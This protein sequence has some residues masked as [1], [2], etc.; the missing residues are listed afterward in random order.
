MSNSKI[1]LT[2]NECEGL[3]KLAFEYLFFSI[4]ESIN[5]CIDMRYVNRHMYVIHLTILLIKV[6]ILFG[7]YYLSFFFRN[8]NIYC[9]LRANNCHF[10]TF[11]KG[12]KAEC[13]HL[14][15]PLQAPYEDLNN[16]A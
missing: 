5:Y 1:P 6:G 9:I 14:K 7:N 16:H 13:T 10:F 15:S 8:R 12:L 11:L 2:P 4:L 3:K